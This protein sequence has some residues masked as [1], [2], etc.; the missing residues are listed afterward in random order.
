MLEYPKSLKTKDPFVISNCKQVNILLDVFK[1]YEKLLEE[2][3]S[4]Y[5]ENIFNPYLSAF[6]RG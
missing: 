3:L 5:F 2:Q 1:M 6:H 4:K